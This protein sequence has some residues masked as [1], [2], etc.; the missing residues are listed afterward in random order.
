MSKVPKYHR[1][2]GV[3]QFYR[4]LIIVLLVIDK[5][6]GPYRNRYDLPDGSLEDGNHY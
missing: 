6:K 4:L 5:I 1:A 2:F 3:R